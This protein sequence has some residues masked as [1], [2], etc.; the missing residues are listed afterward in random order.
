MNQKLSAWA[1]AL[2]LMAATAAQAQGQDE[3]ALIAALRTGGVAVLLRHSQTTPGISDPP[4]FRLDDCAT[5]R[6]L[7]DAGRA[8]AKR[9]GQWFQ[10]HAITPTVVRHSPWCR[11]RD[12]AELAFGRSE[13]WQALAS[14]FNDRSGAEQQAIDVRRYVASL[15]PGEVAVL[16]THAINVTSISASASLRQ[17]EAV[18]VRAA[19]SGARPWPIDELGRIDV[20]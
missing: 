4:G 5:Q 17:G 8:Q 1:M 2:G 12:T 15:K 11:T 9:L 13:P 20:P 3:P 6:N 16:V 10:R 19:R 14:V 7:D 18:V